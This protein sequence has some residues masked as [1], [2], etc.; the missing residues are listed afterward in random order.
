MTLAELPAFIADVMGRQHDYGTI[1]VAIGSIAAATAWAC[2]KHE[3]GGVTGY[4]AGAILWEFARAWGA[5][6]IGKTGARFQN[7]DDLLYPQYGERFT[8]V[9][10]RTWDALQAEAAKNLQGKWDVAHPDVI[11]HWRSIVDGVVPFGLTIGDA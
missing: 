4:Q 5:P 9:S 6:S 8:A 2:N 10:Q 1:C 11:A 7:F 3:H